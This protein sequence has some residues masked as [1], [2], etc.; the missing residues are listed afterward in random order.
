MSGRLL[1]I[2]GAGGLIGSQF[3]RLAPTLASEWT[4]RGLGRDELN[5]TDEHAIRRLFAAEKPEA[6]IHCA[7]MSKTP[8]CQADPSLARRVNVEATAL[9]SELSAEIPFIF[10]STDLVFDGLKGNYDESAAPNPL[11][12]YAETKARAEQ[13]VL[14]NPRHTVIRTSLNGGASPTGDRGFNEE[15]RNAVRSGKTLNLFTD[16]FRNPIAVLV[17]ARAIMELLQRGATGLFHVAGGERLSRWEIGQLLV[18]RWGEGAS[19]LRAGSLRDYTGPTRA[20]DTTLN[21]AKAQSLLSFP[22]PK[23]SEWLRDNPAEPF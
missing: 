10:F 19:Q 15:T 4:V 17:T 21:C 3:V 12:I 7:A 6:I 18:A 9:L 8:A 11:N 16:E 22:L 2:T 13:I 23:F 1:W 14:R 5:L 20:P